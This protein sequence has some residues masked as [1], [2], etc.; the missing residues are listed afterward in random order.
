MAPSGEVDVQGAATRSALPRGQPRAEGPAC[1]LGVGTAVPPAEFLQ[2]EY[3]DFF[4]NIT[5][6]GEK[7][8][9]K[10]KFKRI[11]KSTSTV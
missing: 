8:A 7:D 1:V 9:L 4:F 3:P 11:C 5:N 2:S 10:A 6:C